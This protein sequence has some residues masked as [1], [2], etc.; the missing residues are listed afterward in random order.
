MQRGRFICCGTSPG[1][2]NCRSDHAAAWQPA[3]RQV[4]VEA[5]KAECAHSFMLSNSALHCKWRVL[6]R[7]SNGKMLVL[8]TGLTGAA[9]CGPGLLCMHP[10]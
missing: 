5:A 7:C 9:T 3:W 6:V 1:M 8:Q 10:E 2:D 4:R